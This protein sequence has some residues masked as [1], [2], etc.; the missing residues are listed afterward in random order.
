[1]C[2]ITGHAFSKLGRP[3]GEAVWVEDPA[4]GS[5]ENAAERP[6]EEHVMEVLVGGGS[7]AVQQGAHDHE[8][9]GW[10]WAEWEMVVHI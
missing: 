6:R 3:V 10:H 2:Q 5:A 9:S 8:N 4:E 7:R 1:M